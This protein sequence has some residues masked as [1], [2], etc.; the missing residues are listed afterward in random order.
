MDIRQLALSPLKNF[1]HVVIDVPEWDNAKV[2]IFEPTLDGWHT[3]QQLSG[4][5]G[6]TPA[7][8][9][10]VAIAALLVDVLRDENGNRI[11]KREDISE[12]KNVIAPV[13][14]RLFNEALS[15][16]GLKDIDNPVED[17]EKK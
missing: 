17:A 5:E 7:E 9:N 13:H 2:M 4:I 8:S 11:F 12:L 15:L 10:N 6:L 3:A 1:K 14:S 16:S